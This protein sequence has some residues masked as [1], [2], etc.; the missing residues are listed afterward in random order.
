MEV[1]SL[2]ESLEL[3]GPSGRL[4]LHVLLSIYQYQREFQNEMIRN[5]VQARRK[6]GL[7]IGRPRNER[8][9]A[10]IRKMRLSG[11][12]VQDIAEKIGCSRTNIYRALEKTAGNDD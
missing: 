9:L 6:A 5:G 3:K 1:V 7:P 8:K 12:S 10:K 2:S 11:E 4:V